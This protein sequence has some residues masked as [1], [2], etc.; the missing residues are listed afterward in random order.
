[1]PPS[2]LSLAVAAL[3][4]GSGGALLYPTLLA[5]LVDRTP[6]AERG[7][8]IG[9]LSGSWDVGVVLGSLIVGVT[10]ERVSYAAGF[11][12]AGA[13]AILGLATFLVTERRPR[14]GALCPTPRR[15][16]HS[17]RPSPN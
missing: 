7:L 6:E 4:L 5:L 2:A 3:L 16:Y 12:V 17:S 9:T 15:G 10:V 1:M 8:A 11:A 13:F 14:A